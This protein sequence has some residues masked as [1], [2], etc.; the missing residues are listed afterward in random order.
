VTPLHAAT[1]LPALLAAT[2]RASRGHRSAPEVAAFRMDAERRC[3]HLQ[4]ALRRPLT[5]PDAWQPGP[6][7]TFRLTDPKPRLITV[8]QFS[9]RV[10]H[11]A[12]IAAIEPAL[13]RYAT[14][15]SYACRVGRGQHAAVLQAQRYTRAA[16][17]ALKLDIA[18]YFA[19]IPHDHLLATL[20]RRVRDPGLLGCLTRIVQAGGLQGLPIGALTSQHLANLYL[21]R[22]DHWLTDD[23]GHRRVLRYMDDTL[24][25]GERDALRRL[26]DSVAVF[27]REQL[28]LS[29]NPRVSGLF[30]VRHGVPFLGWRI[31]PRLLRPRPATWKRA[32][33]RHRWLEAQLSAGTI[34]EDE[35]AIIAR[36][37]FAHLQF[38][39][40]HR[41]RCSHLHRMGTRLSRLQ[42]GQPGR[43]LEQQAGQRPVCQSQQEHAV[44]VEQQP[45]PPARQHGADSSGG[46]GL[47]TLVQH[48]S[49]DPTGVQR[50]PG[51]HRLAEATLPGGGT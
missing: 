33:R 30:P 29:L 48:N 37:L 15:G 25:F 50:Q 31:Y 17:W 28:G 5:D 38:G 1:T 14:G 16:P 19:T 36:S 11:H 34:S 32:R 43:L 49:T 20:R 26:W 23:Q 51:L 40:T 12:L 2:R 9:D 10:V 44:Q 22:L 6:A 45:R 7:R 8:S 47:R 13:E 4:R 21:G 18:R 27:L 35:A 39:D 46:G 24:I 3:L 42:P 41:L